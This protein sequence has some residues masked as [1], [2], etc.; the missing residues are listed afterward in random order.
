MVRRRE[1]WPTSVLSM[2]A[3][4][5]PSQSSEESPEAFR[6]GRMAREACSIGALGFPA[7]REKS[8]PR[9]TIPGIARKTTAAIPAIQIRYRWKSE[10]S[11]GLGDA[12]DG[13]RVRA[14]V[15]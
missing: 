9:K 12:A 15:R 3:R 8:L 14:M 11:R 10:T 1:D 4:L 2:S 6:R 5:G 13:N 7:D